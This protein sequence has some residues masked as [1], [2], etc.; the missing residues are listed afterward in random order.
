MDPGEGVAVLILYLVK[1]CVRGVVLCSSS[2]SSR[3]AS[4]ASCS[5][6]AACSFFHVISRNQKKREQRIQEGGGVPSSSG[7]GADVLPP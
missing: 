2:I 3:S 4:V 6:S 7:L 1:K 5:L